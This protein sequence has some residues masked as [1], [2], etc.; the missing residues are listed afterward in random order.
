[1]AFRNEWT[2]FKKGWL[3]IS[4]HTIALNFGFPSN[5]SNHFE[6]RTHSFMRA[7]E[8]GCYD[9]NE[10]LCCH[11]T[12]ERWKFGSWSLFRGSEYAVHETNH[13]GKDQ[14]TINLTL[15]M[16]DDPSRLVTNTY[17]GARHSNVVTNVSQC[18]VLGVLVGQ[19]VA[20]AGKGKKEA[21]CL[22]I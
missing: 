2:L 5:N 22:K 4:I 15:I 6:H 1:M 12:K 18:E 9:I 3:S 20:G 21:K 16:W 14:G 7:W 19:G 10:L 17:P 13:V 8:H 11:R